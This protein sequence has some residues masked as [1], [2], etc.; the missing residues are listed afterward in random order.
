[1]VVVTHGKENVFLRTDFLP[2]EVKPL[3]L[4]SKLLHVPSQEE[5]TD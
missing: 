5:K 2:P 3:S 4:S 1:M